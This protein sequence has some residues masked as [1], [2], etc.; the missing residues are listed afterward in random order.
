[1]SSSQNRSC[2]FL[3]REQCSLVIRVIISP[4]K[5]PCSPTRILESHWWVL[6]CR[7][8]VDFPKQE[9]DGDGVGIMISVPDECPVGVIVWPTP[10]RRNTI[11]R[12]PST[13]ESLQQLPQP[14]TSTE[15][16]VKGVLVAPDPS[17]LWNYVRCQY[18]EECFRVHLLS[19]PSKANAWQDEV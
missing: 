6:F 17:I 18:F 11:K 16:C 3:T 9:D 15:P 8:C 5:H 7:R 13:V 4:H 2:L 19:M 14:T 10:T 12:G 1:M